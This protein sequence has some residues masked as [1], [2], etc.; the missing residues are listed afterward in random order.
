MK[1]KLQ[2]I[3]ITSSDVLVRLNLMCGI[4]L[5]ILEAGKKIDW[6]WV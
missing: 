6:T 1:H 3:G 2:T 4:K 5:V